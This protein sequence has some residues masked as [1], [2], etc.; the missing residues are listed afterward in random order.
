[1]TYKLAAFESAL[2]RMWAVPLNAER[3]R[4]EFEYI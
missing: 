4:V 1:M 2:F 3:R